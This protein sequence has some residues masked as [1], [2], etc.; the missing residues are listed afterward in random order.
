VLVAGLLLI[1]QVAHED[2]LFDR[3]ASLTGSRGRR[4]A[5]LF[6]GLMGLVGAV[7]V[8]LNLDTSVAFLTPILVLAARRRGLAEEPFLYASLFMANAA[9]LLRRSPRS[10]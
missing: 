9:S 8:G 6:V 2:G 4:G 1:G 10:P 7:T 5:V 3:A